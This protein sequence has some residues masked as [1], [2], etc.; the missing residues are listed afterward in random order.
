MP[1]NEHTRTGLVKRNTALHLIPTAGASC[2]LTGT[3][4]AHTAA[5]AAS[6][7]VQQL[8]HADGN[9]VRQSL[10]AWRAMHCGCASSN[11]INFGN[12]RV[13]SELAW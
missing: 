4:S 12:S 2:R 5:C 11:M 10:C 3:S 6:C 8:L 1:C 7:A 9:V 13:K